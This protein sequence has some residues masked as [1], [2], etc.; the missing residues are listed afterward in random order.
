MRHLPAELLSLHLCVVC[1]S[2]SDI[3]QDIHHVVQ[4]CQVTV[5]TRFMMRDRSAPARPP[6]NKEY[7]AMK[8]KLLAIRRRPPDALYTPRD[9]EELRRKGKRKPDLHFPQIW[10]NSDRTGRNRRLEHGKSESLNV[11][12][13]SSQLKPGDR[14]LAAL[15]GTH[16]N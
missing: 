15:R 2:K 1:S 3:C 14:G 8:A 12:T 7:K 10:H 5:R 6:T 11:S 16:L 9:L 4:E 13:L